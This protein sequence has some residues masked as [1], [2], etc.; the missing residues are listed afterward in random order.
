MRCPKCNTELPDNYRFCPNCRTRL[1]ETNMGVAQAFPDAAPKYN[2]SS[3]EQI[4]K[5]KAI[6]SLSVG[7]LARKVTESEF[8]QLDTLRGFIVEDGV[9]VLMY[10]DGEI[11]EVPGGAYDLVSPSA[12]QSAQSYLGQHGNPMGKVPTPGFMERVGRW[13]KSIKNFF[14]GNKTHQ[15]SISAPRPKSDEQIDNIIRNLT[16]DTIVSL[17]LRCER[18]FTL[19]FGS[20]QAAD[21][22]IQFQPL[23]VRT[24]Y[25]DVDMGVSMSLRIIDTRAF[26]SNYMVGRQRVT[27]FLIQQELGRY[28]Q[29]ILQ[30]EMADYVVEN[31]EIDVALKNRIIARLMDLSHVLKGISIE[32]IID[33][34]CDGEELQRFRSVARELYLSDKE[35]DYMRRTNEM[36]NRMAAEVSAAKINEA[37]STFEFRVALDDLN[38]DQLLHQDEMQVFAE[39]MYMLKTQRKVNIESVRME[40]LA[41]VAMKKT[42]V[43]RAV[44]HHAL[45]MDEGTDVLKFEMYKKSRQRELDKLD[46]EQAIYGKEYLIAKQRLADAWQLED[47]MQAHKHSSEVSDAEHETDMLRKR[48]EQERIADDHQFGRTRRQDDYEFESMRRKRDFN[49]DTAMKQ[50]DLDM[51]QKEIEAEQ[52]RRKQQMSMQNM[53]A[54][55]DLDMKLTNNGHRNKMEETN[56]QRGFEL[57]KERMKHE[58]Q[59]QHDSLDFQLGMQKADSYTR[60]GADQIAASQLSKLSD[61]QS[62]AFSEM[63]SSR[64]ETQAKEEMLRFAEGK[65]NENRE[66]MRYMMEQMTRNMNQAMGVNLQTQQN[67]MQMMH[68]S[69][70]MRQDV[71]Q[72][73]MDDTKQMKEEYRE[74]AYHQQERTD[75]NQQQSLNFATKIQTKGATD[76]KEKKNEEKKEEP[77]DD[78]KK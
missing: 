31:G 73:R 78:N 11:V 55:V 58:E 42:D 5:N 1:G 25:I 52:L 70:Q 47:A 60:M 56:A 51:R 8:A 50:Q 19:V 39:Q 13:L 7:E 20:R 3:S 30:E 26:I 10:I 32:R 18:D 6:F 28:V 22:T 41:A 33:I 57:E 36:K 34:T 29:A 66:D 43:E 23:R 48:L 69:M 14:T 24:K 17:Y 37:R 44:L 21:G 67:A 74:Q 15:N 40:T 65:H 59:M 2:P 75:M 9:A 12:I 45:E 64:K 27:S 76:E 4:V 38:R 63:F 49:L 77:K 61:S 54:M 35:L 72:Q 71:L 68:D 16:R 53:Q 46:I 62:A